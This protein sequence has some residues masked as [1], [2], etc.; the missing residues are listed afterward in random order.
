MGINRL[1]KP[2][3]FIYE[4]LRLIIMTIVVISSGGGSESLPRLVFMA[5]GVLFPLMALF[6]WLDVQRYRAYLPLFAAGKCVVIFTLLVWAIVSRRFAIADETGIKAAEWMF[7]SSDIVAIVAVFV[8]SND[9]RKLTETPS[10][11]A[12]PEVN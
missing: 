10:D 12:E 6:I 3:L 2:G 9:M 4:L 5:P 11:T 8:I 1:F 7:L